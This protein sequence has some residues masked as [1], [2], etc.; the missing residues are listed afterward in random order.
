MTDWYLEIQ[1]QVRALRRKALE[2]A[3]AIP[4]GNQEL[5]DKINEYAKL[6]FVALQAKWAEHLPGPPTGD[7]GRHLYFGES[8]DYEDILLWDIPR[9]EEALDHWLYTQ[10]STPHSEGFRSF[11]HSRVVEHALPHFDAGHLREAVLNAFLAVFDLLRERSGF[12]SDGANLVAQALSLDH[13]TL[14]LSDLASESGRN[15]QK[16]FIQIRQGAYL[17]IRNPKAHSLRHDLTETSAAQYFVFA[18]LLAR[19]IEEAVHT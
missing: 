10:G 13:P 6:D 9:M 19:R 1:K 8:H 3:A 16:G 14:I 4:D 2:A 12:D 5:A 17:G 15:D 18:S 11:L 7:L